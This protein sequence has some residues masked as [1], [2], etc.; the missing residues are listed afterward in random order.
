MANI[1]PLQQS[2]D[3]WVRR[4]SVA[5]P[6]YEQGVRNP[7]RQ[8]SEAA[9]QAAD[10][11]RQG[12]TQAA[13]QGRFAAGVRQAGEERW[14]RATLQKGPGRFAE[15]V[16]IGQD[17]WERGFQPFQQA[18]ERVSLP[19]RGPKGSPQNLQRVAVIAN[20]L[21]QVATQMGR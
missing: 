10:N 7:R 20:T 6:D 21:R 4:A 13:T 12:V 15:G 19:D 14:Q 9:A 3:K 17:N 16:A 5:G 11:Y 2:A 1:K 18:I 8:W